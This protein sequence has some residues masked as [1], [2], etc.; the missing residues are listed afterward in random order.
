[1][2]LAWRAPAHSF[3]CLHVLLAPSFDV[4][5]ANV[6]LPVCKVGMQP[7]VTGFA[8]ETCPDGTFS[9]GGT[10]SCKQCP[11]T[12]VTCVAGVLSMNAGY[13]LQQGATT[14]GTIT[15]ESEFHPCWN[16]EACVV[17][18]DRR[19]TTCKAGYTGPRCGVCDESAGY[20]AQDKACVPCWSNATNLALVVVVL[21]AVVAVVAYLSVAHKFTHSS[22]VKIILRIMLVRTPVR[23]CVLP[24]VLTG[25]HVC[26]CVV[27]GVWPVELPPSAG[28]LGSISCERDG[29]VQ[30]G[31]WL[32]RD[33]WHLTIWA[34]FHAVHLSHVVRA[35]MLPVVFTLGE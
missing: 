13:F 21:I 19:T 35:Q 33:G 4:L 22:R 34:A 20:A 24:Q 15:A 9:D 31:V 5:S 18:N 1:M 23:C 28:I 17:H 29:A 27:C 12:G 2:H 32:C 7:G 26:V 3:L 11:A 30:G 6:T 14:N 16:E 25:F 8:C 10:S